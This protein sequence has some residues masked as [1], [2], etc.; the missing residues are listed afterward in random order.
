MHNANSADVSRQRSRY[1]TGLASHRGRAI[2]P[3]AMRGS[4]P[5][6][7]ERQCP[8]SGGKR[9]VAPFLLLSHTRVTTSF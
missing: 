4:G 3:S 7:V 1:H 9:Q 2:N 8:S 5:D 6:A